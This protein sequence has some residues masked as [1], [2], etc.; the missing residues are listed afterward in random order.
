MTRQ[1]RT[2]Q[3]TVKAEVHQR[4]FE[5][6]QAAKQSAAQRM[7]LLIETD[8]SE[9]ITEE[10]VGV[11]VCKESLREEFARF[12]REALAGEVATHGEDHVTWKA[13][14][15]AARCLVN[16]GISDES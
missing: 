6:C 1:H 3:T 4:F 13:A 5:I 15:A 10:T 12:A 8:V 16:L 11:T 9:P 7:R 2:M 14:E